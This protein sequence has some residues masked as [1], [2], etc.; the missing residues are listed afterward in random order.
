MR[1]GQAVHTWGS[2]QPVKKLIS[3]NCF[4]HTCALCCSWCWSLSVE[5][6][7]LSPSGKGGRQ[8]THEAKECNG[9]VKINLQMLTRLWK[10][11][12]L[13]YFSKND[14]NCFLTLQM[15]LMSF[16]FFFKER[17]SLYVEQ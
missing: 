10:L 6:H 4:L 1:K 8:G 3:F 9:V 14:K 15:I 13:V 2:C 12:Q 17:N 5:D 7:T 11:V 16:V